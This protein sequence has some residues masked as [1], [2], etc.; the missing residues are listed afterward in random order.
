MKKTFVV[1][2]FVFSLLLPSANGA[3]TGTFYLDAKVGCYAADKTPKKPH[4]WSTTNYKTLYSTSCNSPHHYEVFSITKLKAK[5]L[6]SDAAQ[7]E[8]STACS[9][10]ARKTINGAEVPAT[11][12]FAY[13]FPDPGAEQKKYGTKTICFFRV[14]DTKSDQY[15]ISISK[16]IVTITYI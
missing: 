10:A 5:N 11:L 12:T 16:P 4:K 7:K 3:T 14:S 15:T 8:A 1:A 9:T 6:A 2:T 13:F